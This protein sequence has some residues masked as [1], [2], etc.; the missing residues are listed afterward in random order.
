[1]KYIIVG[2]ALGIVLGN[3]TIGLGAAFA[4]YLWREQE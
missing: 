4:L 2:T 1:M 3:L